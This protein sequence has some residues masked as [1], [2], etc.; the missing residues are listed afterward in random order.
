M[1]Q[2][3]L[4]TLRVVDN[5]FAGRAKLGRSPARAIRV[6]I[7]MAGKRT[8]YVPLSTTDP[9]DAEAV[10]SMR[11]GASLPTYG[12]VDCT[13]PT[14]QSYSFNSSLS[15]WEVKF[16]MQETGTALAQVDGGGDLGHMGLG[17]GLGRVGFAKG[18]RREASV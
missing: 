10:R 9:W 5:W 14:N 6:D 13:A 17:G 4:I 16:F 3:G 18:T 12:E 1:E 2:R 11:S 8:C 7:R 15:E